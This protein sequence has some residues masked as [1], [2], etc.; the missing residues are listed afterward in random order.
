MVIN[1]GSGEAKISSD[2]LPY[3]TMSVDIRNELL[4]YVKHYKT[5]VSGCGMVEVINHTIKSGDKDKP[6]SIQVEYKIT[7]VFLPSKQ[8]NSGASTDIDSETIHEL[9]HSLLAQGKDTQKLKLHWHSHSDF[10]VFHSGTD[11][12]N[13]ETLNNKDFLVSLVLNHQEDILG[14]ID[15]YTP[16][17]CNIVGVPVYIDIPIPESIDEKVKLNIEALDKYIK[18]NESK[19]ITTTR[20]SS[21]DDW[22][23]KSGNWRGYSGYDDYGYYGDS[24]EDNKELEKLNE[25][26]KLNW[27]E[28]EELM[29]RQAINKI[30]K[31]M[32]LSKKQAKR[33]MECDSMMEC[34]KCV[35]HDKCT[36]FNVKISEIKGA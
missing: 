9:M 1:I 11:T 28:E 27:W 2:M 20:Y 26:G 4:A 16:F 22:R 7:E 24:W 30:R 17:V 31:D 13:Y 36:E 8:D 33:F 10:S 25:Q 5:E 6:D 15:Y 23:L 14:R 32:G 29:E 12:D 21:I 34:D 18:E 19:S 3:I 35:L